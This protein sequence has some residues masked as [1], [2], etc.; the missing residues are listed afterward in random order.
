MK[1]ICVNTNMP[2]RLDDYFVNIVPSKIYDGEPYGE[3][4]Y[5]VKD[6][7]GKDCLYMKYN[8]ERLDDKRHKK[9]NKLGI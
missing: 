7:S 5:L 4:H 3:L 9:L 8:F 2:G 6:D 1:L